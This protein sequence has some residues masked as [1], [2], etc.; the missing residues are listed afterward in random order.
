MKKKAL[1]VIKRVI[2]CVLFCLIKQSAS[3][4][5][6]NPSDWD[7][8]VLSDSNPLVTDTFR[9]QTFARQ[10]T[11]NWNYTPSGDISII[12]TARTG[13]GGK[14]GKYGLKIPM[15]AEVSFPHYSLTSYKNVSIKVH[16]GGMDR[17]K[18]DSLMIRS[19]RIGYPEYTTLIKCEKSTSSYS[20]NSILVGKNPPGIDLLTNTTTAFSADSYYCVDSIYAF[21]EIPAYSLFTSTGN[22][23]DTLRWSHLPAARHRNGLINGDVHINSDIYC[24]HLFIG[25]GSVRI[26][27]LSHLSINSLTLYTDENTST[28]SNYS[29]FL[30]AGTVEIQGKVTVEKKFAQK[31]KWYFISFPFDIYP[32]GIDPAFQLGDEQSQ[33]SGNYFYLKTY[34]GERRANQGSASGNWETVS[35]ST[36]NADTPLFQKGKGYLI[37][38][39]AA[40]EGLT[41]LF[42][43]QPHALPAD[44]GK[45]GTSPISPTIN[46]SGENNDHDGWYLCGNP[47]PSA[48]PLREIVANDALDGF[49]YLYNGSGYR[50]YAIGSDYA[51]PP[52]SAFF[53][54]ASK[55]TELSIRGIS[56]DSR[57][58]I[59]SA[60][61]PLSSLQPEPN[62]STV[63]N[64][65]L[66][67]T[68]PTFLVTGKTIQI[69]NMPSP[70]NVHIFD[71]KGDLVH[72]FSA[73]SG[74]SEI[75][76][77]LS[78]GLYILQ[79]QT[80]QNQIKYKFMLP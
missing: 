19:Y 36:L 24:N 41:L 48:L 47:L 80:G 17:M 14:C 1:C 63:S 21:G 49:V 39:D 76:L 33:A 68:S 4:Q 3:T 27:P 67:P 50:A 40:A 15:R 43:S 6:S 77:S 60:T 20:F 73:S 31:G 59:L 32:A 11:D 30:S 69:R 58:P 53:V 51:L 34:N 66:I 8:F 46:T 25:K 12:E 45:N 74:N 29:P 79:A 52:F 55:E 54:K 56:L 13:I 7:N 64:D 78:R 57:Q 26:L 22:W 61:S 70:G 9:L 10:V 65:Q 42:T 38:L 28:S 5:V 71:F 72:S 37:A 75:R 62:R 35:R 44:F 2:I 16:V 18:G 23:N